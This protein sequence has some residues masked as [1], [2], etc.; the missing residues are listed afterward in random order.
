MSGYFLSSLKV[1]VQYTS[2]KFTLPE[3]LFPEFDYLTQNNDQTFD[4]ENN[5]SDIYFDEIGGVRGAI[6]TVYGCCINQ[7]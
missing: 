4:T 7:W 2:D 5:L 1:C 3:S 6:K